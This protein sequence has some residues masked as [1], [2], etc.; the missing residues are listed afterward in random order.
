MK[1][2]LIILVAIALLPVSAI[3][4]GVSDTIMQDTISKINEVSKEQVDLLSAQLKIAE[5]VSRVG[6]TTSQ[7]SSVLNVDLA[8]YSTEQL[9]SLIAAVEEKNFGEDLLVVADEDE[10]KAKKFYTSLHDMYIITNEIS[11]NYEMSEDDGTKSVKFTYSPID[12]VEVSIN[13]SDGNLVSYQL[14][15]TMSYQYASL[16]SGSILLSF[17]T[18]FCDVSVNEASGV[19]EYLI[20]NLESASGDLGSIMLE[21]SCTQY[22]YEHVLV[23]S[24]LVSYVMYNIYPN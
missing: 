4:E 19:V 2:F 15:I 14:G 13:Y 9:Q 20:A 8:D 3:A 22:G 18:S 16:K 23:K 21:S 1:K 17:V 11:C 7:Y 12:G 24:S 6:S 10:V 5:I